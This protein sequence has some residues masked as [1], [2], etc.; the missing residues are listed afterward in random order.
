MSINDDPI[1]I[2]KREHTSWT[3]VAPGWGKHDARLTEIATPVASMMLDLAG[4]GPG[5]RILDIACGTGEP[6]IPAAERAKGGH[7]IAIDF[8]EEMLVFAREKAKVRGLQNIEFRRV[9]GEELNFPDASFD[10]VTMRWGLMFM[11]DPLACLK[12]AHR[13]LKH[14]GRIV[15]ACWGGPQQNLWASLPMGIIRR[16]LN[17]TL[18]PP[19]TAGLFAFA[20]QSRLTSIFE[21]AGFSNVANESVK[22]TMADF[23]TGEEYFAWV[24]ELAGPVANLFDQIPPDRQP[25]VRAEIERASTGEGGRVM[26]TGETWV[27]KG[28]R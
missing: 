21:E 15:A 20:D 10:A 4:V 3:N 12:R 11:S 2:K 24:G 13:V 6:A 18:P 28:I 9:D 1:E 17:L 25:A 14:G 23:D 27:V 22:V 5:Q 7:V 19:G 26:F 16:E 8:V